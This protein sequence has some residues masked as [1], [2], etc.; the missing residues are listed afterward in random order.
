MLRDVNRSAPR[1]LD[2]WR[3]HWL[4]DAERLRAFERLRL[5]WCLLE[6]DPP[7]PTRAA[8]VALASRADQLADDGC[9]TA[10]Y[11]LLLL[12]TP[13]LEIVGA[14]GQTREV[15]WRLR[16]ALWGV[17]FLAGRPHRQATKDELIEALWPDDDPAAVARNFHPTLS[18]ARRT[19]ARQGGDAQAIEFAEG[20]YR[21]APPAAWWVDADE[22]ERR[23]E[24]AS[25][26][27][28]GLEPDRAGSQAIRG[29]ILEDLRQAW[30]LYRGPFLD[31]QR[32]RGAELDWIVTRREA[33]RQRHLEVLR[34]VGELAATV[35]REEIARDAWRT[36]L[37]DE[38]FDEAAHL[39]VMRLD[40]QRGRRDLV[41]KQYVRLQDLLK[42]LRVEPSPEA[43]A[44]YHRLMG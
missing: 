4:D 44:L 1:P 8:A 15:R 43:R 3:R 14:D 33:L 42:E 18:D 19:V 35:G 30:R 6:G 10:R 23:I 27:L 32:L 34:L 5:E 36:L 37:L 25:E 17:A 7:R 21:L 20:V 26:Q 40:A 9:R 31:G 2:A 16:R 28:P 39:A 13:R 24:R 29:R 38:P 22:L 41:R 11:R 12:G